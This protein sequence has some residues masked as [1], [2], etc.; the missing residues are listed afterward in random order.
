VTK[1][2]VTAFAIVGGFFGAL[3]WR[4][5]LIMWASALASEELGVLDGIGFWRA[6]LLGILLGALKSTFDG[7]LT[8]ATKTARAT[9]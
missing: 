4:G 2:F 3:A 9:T 5:A 1:L 7:G 6:T 8:R